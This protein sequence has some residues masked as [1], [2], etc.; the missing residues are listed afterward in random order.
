VKAISLQANKTQRMIYYLFYPF[1]IAG[2]AFTA[3]RK[4]N[5][6]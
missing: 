4:K 6:K 3:R 5:G 1:S 2:K